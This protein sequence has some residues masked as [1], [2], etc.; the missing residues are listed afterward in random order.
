MDYHH[1]MIIYSTVYRSIIYWYRM[2]M[3]GCDSL[4]VSYHDQEDMW[5]TDRS[6]IPSASSWGIW[7]DRQGLSGTILLTNFEFNAGQAYSETE[8]NQFGLFEVQDGFQGT[9]VQNRFVGRMWGTHPKFRLID[10]LCTQPM[11]QVERI[12]GIA[13]GKTHIQ[14]HC[15]SLR[16]LNSSTQV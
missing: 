14:T 1:I 9:L 8:L 3:G 4:I 16:F 13:L 10:W 6:Y 2:M 15:Y 11:P 7:L 12:W 5:S